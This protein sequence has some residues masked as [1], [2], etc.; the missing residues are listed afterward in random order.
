MEES[1]LPYGIKQIKSSYK[2]QKYI[3]CQNLPNTVKK[4]DVHLYKLLDAKKTP[5]S[6]K[7]LNTF[8]NNPISPYISVLKIGQLFTK[9]ERITE[10]KY[11][12]RLEICQKREYSCLHHDIN[13]ILNLPNG[14]KILKFGGGCRFDSD[15][16]NLPEGLEILHLGCRFNKSIDKLPDTL[17]TIKIGNK[18][19]EFQKVITKLPNKLEKLYLSRMYDL[20]N[21]K[22]NTENIQIIIMK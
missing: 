7:Y 12:T 5:K 6:L 13:I 8:C 18:N 3:G 10:L 20:K 11:L 9:F 15:L 19:S 4:M 2:C 22:T 16:I 17:K 21:I 1:G 14:L